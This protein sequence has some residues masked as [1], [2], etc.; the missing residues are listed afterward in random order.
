MRLPTSSIPKKRQAAQNTSG[1]Q[2]AVYLS[3]KPKQKTKVYNPMNRDHIKATWAVIPVSVPHIKGL[4]PLC[5]MHKWICNKPLISH[6]HWGY[7]TRTTT[8]K[9][10]Q[11]TNP[12]HK[13]WHLALAKWKSNQIKNQN[14]KTVL[15]LNMTRI[16]VK[17]RN[18]KLKNDSEQWDWYTQCL[19]QHHQLST[20]FVALVVHKLSLSTELIVS[21]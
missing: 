3:A 20:V 21:C 12:N 4:L 8:Q 19:M 10:H 11:I 7:L 16:I 2:T 6:K 14:S 18:L 17:T 13:N 1:C 5:W 15:K 9:F